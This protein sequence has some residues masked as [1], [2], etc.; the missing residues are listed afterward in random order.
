MSEEIKLELDT[1]PSL[2][3]EPFAEEKPAPV[4][5]KAQPVSVEQ[6]PLTPEEQK[7]VDD[8]AQKRAGDVL[9]RRRPKENC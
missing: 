8:F 3:L 9:R 1:T 2:T 7:M 4:E 5:E 6:T